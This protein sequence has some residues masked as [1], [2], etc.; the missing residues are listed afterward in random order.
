MKVV[1]TVTRDGWD[2]RKREEGRL[3]KSTEEYGQHVRAI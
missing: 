3:R 1:E 2:K